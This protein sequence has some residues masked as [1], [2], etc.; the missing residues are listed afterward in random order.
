[1]GSDAAYH[2]QYRK[3]NK[4]RIREIRHRHYL[5]EYEPIYVRR[6]RNI[7]NDYDFYEGELQMTTKD[8]TTILKQFGF[9]SPDEVR[10]II[11]KQKRAA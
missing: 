7:D 11:Q 4:A 9:E 5:K 2:R 1:M 8:Y 6:P 10:E 3:D